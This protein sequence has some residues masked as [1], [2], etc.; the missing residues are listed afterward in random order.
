MLSFWGLREIKRQKIQ[1]SKRVISY[2][3][4]LVI[5][6]IYLELIKVSSPFF[7]GKETAYWLIK[8]CT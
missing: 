8:D 7:G 6:G 4:L 3:P 1:I 2:A 5:F